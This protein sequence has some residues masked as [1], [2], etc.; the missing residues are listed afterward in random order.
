M[1]K[2][3]SDPPRKYPIFLIIEVH[4]QTFKAYLNRVCYNILDH[5]V[6]ERIARIIGIKHF[7]LVQ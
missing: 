2:F 5:E 4:V 7:L 3:S 1:P 6:Q